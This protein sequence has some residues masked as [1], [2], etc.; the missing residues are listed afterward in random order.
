MKNKGVSSEP[1]IKKIIIT[2]G[3]NIIIASDGIWDVID[4]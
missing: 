2:K 1:Y 4:D 3:S